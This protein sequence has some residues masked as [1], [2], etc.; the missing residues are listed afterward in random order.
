M[1]LLL[2]VT[3]TGGQP[4]DLVAVA[5]PDARV[6][7]LAEALAAFT[8]AGRLPAAAPGAAL[9]ALF[10]EAT[11]ER[12][13]A[14]ARLAAAGLVSGEALA[15][16]ARPDR[17]PAVHPEVQAEQLTV[18]VLAGP[19]AGRSLQ[20]GPGQ[21][22]AGRGQAATI[23]IEDPAV[24]RR[25]FS[26]HVGAGA[27]A[28]VLPEDP[29]SP[30]VLVDGRPLVRSVALP[31]ESV[32]QVGGTVLVVRR[33]MPLPAQV[34]DRLGCIPFHRTPYRPSVV[35]ER[36]FEP[37][38]GIP[39]RP[40]PRRL[41]LLG[42]LAPL[43]GGLALYAFSRQP[44]F[45]ALMALTP[46]T[47]G[48]SWLE[49]RRA[50]GRRSANDAGRFRAELAAR[51]DAVEAAVQAERIERMRAAPDASELARRAELRAVGLW[52]RGRGAAD[53]LQLRLGLGEQAS[54]VVCP[55]ASEGDPALRREALA[56][57]G[58]YDRLSPV[59]IVVAAGELSTLAVHG[60]DDLVGRVAASLVV[61]AATLHSPED[62]IL[63]AAVDRHRPLANHIAW[64]PHTRSLSS[65]LASRHVVTS[66]A[67]GQ[68]LCA[69][70][71]GVAKRRTAA[72]EPGADRCWPRLLV[73]LDEALEIDAAAVGRL[74]DQAPRAGISVV[75]LGRSE[76]RIPRQAEAVL[77]CQ[78]GRLGPSELWFRD[79]GRPVTTLEIEPL[80]P[81]IAD[82]AVRALAPLRDASSSTATS[83]I[84]RV[85]P[86]FAALGFDEHLPVADAEAQ[87]SRSI[88]ERWVAGSGDA[89]PA[90]LGLTA[91]GI[92][93]LDLVADGPHVLIGG[94]SGSGKS[95]LLVAL[96][97]GLIASH[98]PE[99][100]NLLFVDYK[101]GAA[102][103]E[104][105][106][107]PH[108]VGYVTNL[109]GDLAN[110]ALVSLRAEL[111]RRMR[112]LEGRAKDLG[113]MLERHPGEAPPSLVIVVDEFATL[114]KEIPDFVPGIVD[115]AQRGRSLGIH[116]ILAT[117]RPTGAVNEN[118]LA[119]TNARLCLRMIDP[120]ESSAIIGSPDAAF[121]PV[122]LRGRG[123][124]RLGPGE[125]VAF[126][127]AYGGTPLEAGEAGQVRVRVE[128]ILGD[129]PAGPAPR[130]RDRPAGRTQLAALAS[131]VDRAAESL[132]VRLPRAPWL[133]ELPALIP[134]ETV[135]RGF[136][137]PAGRWLLP[138]GEHD[139]PDRQRQ[140]TVTIDLE[141][142]GGLLVFGAAGSGKTTLVRTLAAA[143]VRAAPA[144]GVVLFALDF[145]SRALRC[146]EALPA[147]AAVVG[148]D[149]LEAVTRV[150]AVLEREVA[151]RRGLLAGAD[152]LSAHL[153]AG[154]TGVP[155]VLAFVDGYTAMRDIFTGEGASA[156]LHGWMDR[157]HRIVAEGRQVGVHVVIT[158]DRPGAVAPVLR[159]VVPRRL[160]LRQVDDRALID[161]G[162][163]P[164]RARGLELGPGRGLLDAALVVQVACV[165]APA[166]DGAAQAARLR[167]IGQEIRREIGRGRGPGTVPPQLRAAPLTGSERLPLAPA[168]DG[169]LRRLLAVLG[170][171]DVTGE[172]VAVDLADG[173]L[174][175]AGP[176]KSGRTTALRAVCSSLAASGT[177]V[178]VVGP[179]ASPLRRAALPGLAAFG[180]GSAIAALGT[181]LA[182][183]AGAYPEVPRVLLVDDADRLLDDAA[184]AG[185][186]D[187]AARCAGVHVVAS[188]ETSS[189][190][191]GYFQ[192][193]L[194]QE[195]KKARRRLLLQPLD[196][197][198]LQ[199]VLGVRFPLRPGLGL[200]PGRGVLLA[201]R[202]PVAL[203]VG[204]AEI[205]M[206]EPPA[207]P[208]RIGG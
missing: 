197:G 188:L 145:A 139:D 169:K 207:P 15:V 86:L 111:N 144:D 88:V 143:A 121:I 78:P 92:L 39:T 96:V 36:R 166:S 75:W 5:D 134:L 81:D 58:G 97:S 177:E 53:F 21:Y 73:V 16:G 59:P 29:G 34:R 79:P 124:A 171:A 62:L 33:L 50:G 80:A 23:S 107:T 142:G 157:F 14:G 67:A 55:I 191:S 149:D 174:V 132:Q 54:R 48:A 141:E 170:V 43:A 136:R 131:A 68:A 7:A 84:P 193:T 175:V 2:R 99:R 206:P 74:L 103:S 95:E 13:D 51:R 129:R 32:I 26:L 9:P 184:A 10:R 153:S 160:V 156:A 52:P 91:G 64:L 19:E 1:E 159:S 201:G 148:G 93:S 104:F 46:V 117:Q 151:R 105:R 12:L 98:S 47:M 69:Q 123:L 20:L 167:E 204:L 183:L 138:L 113:E 85:V 110:R 196:A 125:L 61:Q 106:A 186:L 28:V 122:P 57:L 150:L 37:L 70:L 22:L 120:A 115:I 179:P 76:A 199:A 17:P 152:S 31:E 192:S 100:L 180:D 66:A 165:S 119:N 94:T 24:P 176:A 87:L 18:V 27:R 194:L 168:G 173:P 45:L 208:A 202:S 154:G 112:L 56:A 189:L 137:S 35:T 102:S 25:A 42:S 172:P 181:E 161:L 162:V 130:E 11:G 30:D 83:A 135:L 158:A 65:P 3:S 40:E 205:A 114:V 82:R 44:E 182:G 101:G 147:C 178:Y 118:I 72:R 49:E 163:P 63:L 140:D 200:P 133:D 8:A 127:G 60:D 185:A 6:G 71:A 190:L 89:L 146:L 128:G 116:L 4:C 90:P 109:S 155:R 195:L 38:D 187:R 164:A 126:Q 41:P 77:R 198:E 108:T 203:Q